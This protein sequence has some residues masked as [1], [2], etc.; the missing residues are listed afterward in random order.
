MG[1]RAA[2]G[3]RLCLTTPA[4]CHQ[5]ARAITPNQQPRGA[6]YSQLGSGPMPPAQPCSCP[7]AFKP[8]GEQFLAQSM[9]SSCG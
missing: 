4:A 5:T 8:S 6:G 1:E 3:G 9:P 7:P 2:R